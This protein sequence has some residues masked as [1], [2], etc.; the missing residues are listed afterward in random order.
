MAPFQLLSSIF[1]YVNV[2][3][4]FSFVKETS[5]LLVAKNFGSESTENVLFYFQPL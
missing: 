1:I 4:P 5:L 2:V 3:T